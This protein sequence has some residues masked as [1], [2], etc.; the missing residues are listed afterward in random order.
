VTIRNAPRQLARW[1]AALAQTAVGLRH[2]R[3]AFVGDSITMGS[4]SGPATER[5]AND[6]QRCIDAYPMSPPSQ[7]ARLL[8]TA[9]GQDN[10]LFGDKVCPLDGVEG[11]ASYDRRV[12]FQGDGWIRFGES[13]GGRMFLS[14]RHGDTLLFSPT[15]AVDRCTVYFGAAPHH[16]GF[17]IADSSSTRASVTRYPAHSELGRITVERDVASTDPFVITHEDGHDI[18]IGGIECW[19]S[20][21]PTVQVLNLGIF[22]Q[23]AKGVLHSEHPWAFR[24]AFPL[25]A[26]DLTIIQLGSNDQSAGIPIPEFR[27]HLQ[28]IIDLARLSGDV[29]LSWRHPALHEDEGESESYRQAHIDVAIENEV[30]LVDLSDLYV[31][32]ERSRPL[33]YDGTH[34]TAAGS[35]LIARTWLS[36]ID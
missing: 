12:A 34:Q 2:G 5:D 31:S 26:P 7:L 11:F 10:A 30:P 28:T 25:L 33:Y 24:Q 22:G 9:P 8:R 19:N 15:A 16:G 35:N 20:A 13:L 29:I 4:G 18:V 6:P 1:R 21:L 23:S 17:S 3:V 32:F 27:G 36:L 14:R